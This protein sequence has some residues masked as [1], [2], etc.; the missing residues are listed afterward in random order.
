MA[1]SRAAYTPTNVHITHSLHHDWTGWPL[2]DATFPST[3]P[4]AIRAAAPLW[5]GDG[6]RL[7]NSKPTPGTIQL[8]FAVGPEAS[9]MFLASRVKGRLQHA[10]REGGTPVRFSRKV[11]V[12]TLGENTRQDVEGYVQ[13]QVGKEGF[14]D[15]RYVARMKE[16]AV[17]RHQTDLAQPVTSHSGRYWYN[18]H[19]VLVVGGRR[20]IADYTVLAAIR[21]GVCEAADASGYRLKSVSVMPDHVHVALGGKVDES[22]A[23]IALGLMNHLARRLRLGRIWQNGCYVGTFSEYGLDAI[24]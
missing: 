12:R 15:P 24:R 3:A 6:L 10:F 21:N 14:I 18:L 9:P 16:Y 7:T 19:V 23:A 17:E 1:R 13:K 20:R 4:A 8:C 5:A 2:E 22:P 11:A